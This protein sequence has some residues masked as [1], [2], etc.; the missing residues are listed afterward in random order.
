MYTVQEWLIHWCLQNLQTTHQT[1]VWLQII[2]DVVIGLS[3]L[4]S[5][6][7]IS[8]ENKHFSSLFMFVFLFS[9]VAITFQANCFR[10]NVC[11]NFNMLALL[12]VEHQLIKTVT[13]YWDLMFINSKKCAQCIETAFLFI[14][15]NEVSVNGAARKRI[16]D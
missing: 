6:F 1:Q 15:S 12:A 14:V 8:I 7:A 9:F 10:W 16:E 11:F 5:T 2:I 3:Y 4:L 13:V